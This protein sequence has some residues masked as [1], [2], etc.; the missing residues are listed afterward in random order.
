MSYK[1]IPLLAGKPFRLD[2]PGKVLLIDAVGV[3][4]GIDVALIEGGSDGAVMVARKPGF[5]MITQFDGVI[6][7]AAVDTVVALFLA[8]ENVDLGTNQL[9]ISNSVA[10]PVNV[11]FAGTVAPVVGTISN[12]DAQAVPVIQKA[13][14]IFQ[15][16]QATEV[17]V[18]PYLATVVTNVAPVAVTAAATVMLALGATRRSV[19]FKNVG[20]NPVAIGGAAVV[21]ANA[22]VLIQPGETWVESDAPGAAWYAICGAALASTLNIQTVA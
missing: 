7:T 2:I 22:A 4:G 3:A 9:E 11:L 19:R 13:G 21:F 20:V 1:I 5:K 18:R 14:H 16:E 10:N 12:T 15:V 6:L 17:D 8:M